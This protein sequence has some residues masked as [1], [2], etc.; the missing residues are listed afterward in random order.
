MTSI[1]FNGACFAKG[2]GLDNEELN[3][4]LWTNQLAYKYF[5]NPT[6]TN[7]AIAGQANDRIFVET[8]SALT[9]QH[10]DVVFIEWAPARLIN[11]NVGLEQYSTL[12]LLQNE[13]SINLNSGHTVASEWLAEIGTRLKQ[14]Q[15]L[16]WIILDIVKYV[17]ILIELQV[18]SRG[19]KIFFVNS[20]RTWPNN[21]FEFVDY[22]VPSDLDPFYRRLLETDQRSDQ[23]IRALYNMIHQQ[24][25]QAG[26]IQPEY[27]LNLYQPLHNMRV[28]VAP[29]DLK[30][31]HPGLESQRV[32]V[33][34][35]GQN[36]EKNTQLKQ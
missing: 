8:L 16:H 20:H 7:L 18:R 3:P 28:D 14:I 35:L 9:Q 6:I 17:N 15:N 25:A 23:D 4:Q 1:L 22:D 19:A 12:S 2:T 31:Q 32:F 5:D 29:N 27:W 30:H 33:E 21:Y 26:G 24:Y 10:Y 36:L 11:V 13:G 34:L